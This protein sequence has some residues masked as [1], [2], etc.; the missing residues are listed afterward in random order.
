MVNLRSAFNQSEIEYATRLGPS[1]KSRR[2]SGSSAAVEVHARRIRTLAARRNGRDFRSER[3]FVVNGERFIS[4]ANCVARAPVR[5]D[6]R[7]AS[8]PN[9]IQ[10]DAS[11]E[12]A[13]DERKR[14]KS[15]HCD[16]EN[17]ST[18]A[19]RNIVNRHFYC[20]ILDPLSPRGDVVVPVSIYD[21][22]HVAL[23]A[24]AASPRRFVFHNSLE[25]GP[26]P[27]RAHSMTLCILI[28]QPYRE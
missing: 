4:G 19:T 12:D 5:T 2:V 25:S 15:A 16:V 17:S 27:E 7:A 11:A 13:P 18:D 9:A 6:S 21:T 10:L 1:T 22:A 23:R 14:R 20:F 26:Q 8:K 3:V 24:P 28:N